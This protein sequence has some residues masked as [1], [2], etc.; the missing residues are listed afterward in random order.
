MPKKHFLG[1][2]SVNDLQCKSVKDLEESLEKGDTGTT[3]IFNN[4]T[5]E[6]KGEHWLLITK[7]SNNNV[8]FY[9]SFG[10]KNL[11]YSNYGQE[12][13]YEAVK[14]GSTG[15]FSIVKVKKNENKKQLKINAKYLNDFFFKC[16]HKKTILSFKEQMQSFDS[17][18]CGF[19]CILIYCLLI[20]QTYLIY[21][22]ELSQKIQKLG[23]KPNREIKNN[24]IVE[25]YFKNRNDELK[26]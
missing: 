23:Q 20:E 18:L 22:A 8:F 5:D 19:Y 11:H 17:N 6:G 3:L 24:I 10:A 15:K 1:V 14:L 13:R 12:M 4:T 16:F 2:F 7:I 9:D 26:D 25:D 21:M